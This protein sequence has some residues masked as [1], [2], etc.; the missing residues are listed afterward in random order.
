MHNHGIFTFDNDAQKSYT[1]MIEAVSLAEDFLEEHA[2]ITLN[3]CEATNFYIEDLSI[4]KFMHINP[5]PSSPTL[6]FTR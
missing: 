5:K 6:R 4:S 3:E 1:K 2:P